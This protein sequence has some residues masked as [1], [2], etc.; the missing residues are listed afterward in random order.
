MELAFK[1]IIIN[2]MTL[3]ELRSRGRLE[4]RNGNSSAGS[5]ALRN[6]RAGFERG[7]FAYGKNDPSPKSYKNYTKIRQNLDITGLWNT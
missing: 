4:Q 6:A 5:G 3:T 2:Q 1:S 7:G